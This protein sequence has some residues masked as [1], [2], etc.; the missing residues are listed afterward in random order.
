MSPSAHCSTARDDIW[1]KV[2]CPD[3]LIRHGRPM[4]TSSRP[5]AHWSKPIPTACCGAPT[6]RTRTWRRCCP[7]DGALVDVIPQIAPT[8]Q[9]QHK[10]LVDQS[11]AALLARGSL[12]IG[13]TEASGK[14]GRLILL[15]AITALG[16]LAIQIIVPALPLLAEGIDATPT[17]GQLVISVYLVGL[18]LGQLVWAPIADHHGRRP[19]AAL[20]RRD[21]PDRDAVLRD[22]RR[23]GDDAG[24]P[25][26]PVDRGSL[27]SRYR[28][29][30]GDRHRTRRQGGRAAGDPDQRDADL[31]HYRAGDRRRGDDTGRVA[32][33]VLHP[34]RTDGDRRRARA[35]HVAG[36]A[37]GRPA[38]AESAAAGGQLLAGGA[39]WRRICRSQPPMR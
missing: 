17:S 29:S 33:T 24:G 18:A 9:L 13:G 35:A 38:P 20:G 11:D 32:Y 7:D 10:L 36:D 39:A 23:S 16:S 1:T 3:R 37:R 5:C 22:R 19:R 27:I 14:T 21:L 34:R 8:A 30:D 4:P 25:R 26:D 28:A 2:T 12:T 6:G 15:G 31:A